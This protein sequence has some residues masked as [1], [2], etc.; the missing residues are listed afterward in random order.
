MCKE[1]EELYNDGIEIGE[2]IAMMK[3]IQN[4]M[5]N[6]KKQLKKQWIF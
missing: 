4:V 6:L 2:N 5:T 3:S 1:L